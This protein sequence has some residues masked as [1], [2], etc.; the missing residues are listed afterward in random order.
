M[1]GRS[2]LVL[3]GRMLIIII[4]FKC[5]VVDFVGL[6]DL[7]IIKGNKYIFI[8]VDYVIWYLEVVLL[9]GIEIECVVEVLV[10][11][12]SCVGILRELLFD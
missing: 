11:I 7:W 8:L 9:L 12:F 6:F 5:V 3:F 4:L 1:K 2:K 10:D